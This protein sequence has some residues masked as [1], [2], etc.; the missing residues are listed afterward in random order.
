MN[1]SEAINTHGISIVLKSIFP[2]LYGIDFNKIKYN[3]DFDKSGFNHNDEFQDWFF[4]VGSM[5]LIYK[6]VDNDVINIE[7]D[8][9]LLRND[10]NIASDYSKS[11]SNIT[12]WNGDGYKIEKL[13]TNDLC[14]IVITSISS[15][16]KETVAFN[17]TQLAQITTTPNWIS[18]LQPIYDS[19]SIDE[20]ERDLSKFI[21]CPLFFQNDNEYILIPIQAE[22]FAKPLIDK[23]IGDNGGFKVFS[24]NT[25]NDWQY[26][27]SGHLF[28]IGYLPKQKCVRIN[29]KQITASSIDGENIASGIH[30]LSNQINS[31]V[32][33]LNKQ[34]YNPADGAVADGRLV[35]SSEKAN[36]IVAFDT[37]SSNLI[38]TLKDVVNQYNQEDPFLK[39]NSESVKT[40]L[41]KNPKESISFSVPNNFQILLSKSNAMYRLNL[42][43]PGGLLGAWPNDVPVNDFVKLPVVNFTKEISTRQLPEPLSNVKIEKEVISAKDEQ[44]EK[45]VAF[46]E[47]SIVKEKDLNSNIRKSSKSFVFLKWLFIIIGIL[48][49][50]LSLRNCS[51]RDAEYYYNRGV[52][53]ADSGKFDKAEKDFENAMD[54]DKSYID[55]YIS[56]AEM[57]L[58]NEEYQNAKYDLNE[59]ILLDPENWYAYYLRG[60][61]NMKLATS[62]Y[63]RINEYA[64][65]DFTSS[66]A[67]KSSNEN[68]KSYYYRGKVY[69]FTDNDNSC[70]DFYQACE[71]NTLDACEIVNEICRPKTGFMPFNKIFG[72]GIKTGDRDFEVV[73]K[74]DYDMVISIK[75]IT[76]RRVVRSEYLRS[77]ETL[78][79]NQIPNGR[80]IVEYLQG[81]NWSFNKTLSDGI[82]KG[83]FLIDQK[84]KIIN[85]VYNYNGYRMR[86]FESCSING[87]IT[88]DEISEDQ[89]FN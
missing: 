86:G 89:F 51:S 25:H 46:I 15:I 16:T 54:I 85:T 75:D 61:A 62:K 68:G 64:I 5:P 65:K 37:N 84:T 57:Y 31:I 74:C 20:N 36:N 66:L 73:N 81:I 82:S 12:F 9:I 70:A 79:I 45:K 78:I 87:N 72:P 67:L 8:K 18:G 42:F 21:L 24:E 77:G 1:I 43:P 32:T 2:N 26:L 6:H 38:T 39:I 33:G 55:P 30:P 56:R 10:I 28:V 35:A 14:L 63:S 50:F 71:F 29:R 44:E 59:A 13:I 88:S 7:I 34:I 40:W 48:L 22:E 69:L 76:S 27:Y 60:V 47:S 17:K 19:N 23:I 52:N 58:Q 41:D 49:L 83:G 11:S 3:S 4:A 80:Y 53:R